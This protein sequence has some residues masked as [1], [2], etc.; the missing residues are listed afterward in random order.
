[1]NQATRVICMTVFVVAAGCGF[2]WAQQPGTDPPFERMQSKLKVRDRVTVDLANGL[3][4]EGRFLTV[5]AGTLTVAT[6]AGERRLPASDV[7]G[8]RRH[9]RGVLLGTIIGGGVGLAF[10]V[11]V[12]SILANEGHD[13]D[14]A[15][16]GLTAL[17]LGLGAGIDALVNIPRTVYQRTPSRTALRVIVAPRITAVGVVLTF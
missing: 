7:A 17:G 2:S 1:M 14:P 6:T 4:V 10:G 16:F 11:T 5:A 12:G 15:L 9:R 13:R 3:S 8:V